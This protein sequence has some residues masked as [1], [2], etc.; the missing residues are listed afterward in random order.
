MI[1]LLMF[2]IMY[3][4]PSMALIISWLMIGWKFSLGAAPAAYRK[5]LDSKDNA[6]KELVKAQKEAWEH[7][8]ALWQAEVNRRNEY[9]KLLPKYTSHIDLTPPEKAARA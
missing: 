8:Q 9:K 6:E 1:A 2:I 4:G 7:A 3:G 5:Q